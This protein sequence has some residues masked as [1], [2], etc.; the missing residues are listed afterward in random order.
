MPK[1]DEL[2]TLIDEYAADQ[3]VAKL[4]EDRQAKRRERIMSL[5]AQ[6]R[7][8]DHTTPAGIAAKIVISA[9]AAWSVD[10]LKAALDAERFQALCPPKPDSTKLKAVAESDPVLGPKLAE[11]R[12]LAENASLRISTPKNVA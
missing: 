9:T 3:A 2:D 12:V 11:C 5:M 1:P 10:K 4:T 8:Q 6:R 7:K